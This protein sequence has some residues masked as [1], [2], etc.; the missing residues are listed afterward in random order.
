VYTPAPPDKAAV[1]AATRRQRAW[2]RAR[3]PA[4][5][6]E[7]RERIGGEAGKQVYRRRS[8]IETVNGI[9]KGRGLGHMRVRSMAKIACVVLI[10]VLAHNLWRAHNLGRA[11]RLGAATA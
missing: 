7:W 2:C 5:V 8:R 1:S 3:E 11:H 4:A 6:N 10:Q 9:L